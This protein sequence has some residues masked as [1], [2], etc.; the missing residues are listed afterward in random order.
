MAGDHALNQSSFSAQFQTEQK[1]KAGLMS[2][3]RRA[4]SISTSK[5][6]LST[7]NVVAER[8]RASTMSLSASKTPTAF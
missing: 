3:F 7:T 5:K 8:E 1:K 6:K 4:M 2:S